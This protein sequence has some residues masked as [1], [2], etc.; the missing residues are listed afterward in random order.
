LSTAY[1]SLDGSKSSKDEKPYQQFLAIVEESRA[2]AMAAAAD[3]E[4]AYS[5]IRMLVPEVAYPGRKFLD[6]CKAANA[7]PDET[8]VDRERARQ[9][10]EQAIHGALGH[11]PSDAGAL[12][13]VSRPR[14]RLALR[15][16][17]Q[18]VMERPAIR[19]TA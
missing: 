19:K 1:I 6:L 4:N 17:R 18:Q 13:E 9:M 7:Y 16:G 11:A 12:V 2:S 3:A 10:T 8:K 15:R 5:A 14:R